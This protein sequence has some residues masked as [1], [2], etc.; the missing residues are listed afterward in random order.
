M[1]EFKSYQATEF[2]NDTE[3]LASLE[4]GK[5]KAQDKAYVQ[6]L[7]AK[8]KKAKGLTHREA[9]T[10]LHIKDETILQEMFKTAKYIKE[11]IYGKRIVLFA[12]LYVSNYCV[13]NCAYCG[14]H[15]SNKDL[16]RKK[17]TM[18]ELKDE[19]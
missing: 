6:E 12:P 13:N 4:F 18:E 15:Q 11:K 14:Y 7:L 5:K 17:L 10:L 3:I 19:V 2:I 16:V 8:A 1:Q 9:A